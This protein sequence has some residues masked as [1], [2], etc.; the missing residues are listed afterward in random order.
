MIV[1]ASNCREMTEKA[2]DSINE[3]L[4]YAKNNGFTLEQLNALNM[5]NLVQI[6]SAIANSLAAI[7]DNLEKGE[8][9]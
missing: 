7:A 9:Q 1:K 2:I 4:N 6:M 3:N 8:Q 5:Q